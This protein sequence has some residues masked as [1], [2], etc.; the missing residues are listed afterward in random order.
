MLN[1]TDLNGFEH[2]IYLTR[3]SHIQVR[4]IGDKTIITFHLVGPHTL[5][6]NLHKKTA[7]R[8]LKEIGVKTCI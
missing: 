7:A 1:F 8:I 6:V 3:I 5:P 2:V 4:E